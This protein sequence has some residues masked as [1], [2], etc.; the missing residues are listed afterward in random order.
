MLPAKLNSDL[1]RHQRQRWGAALPIV[2]QSKHQVALKLATEERAEHALPEQVLKRRRQELP[3]L[4]ARAAKVGGGWAG[5]SCERPA[6]CRMQWASC[7]GHRGTVEAWL[8]R[9]A[10][11]CCLDC[12]HA[13]AST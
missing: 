1:A 11:G 10:A 13:R 4:K 3:A 5:R 2:T 7:V 9:T 12:R 6:A 8:K